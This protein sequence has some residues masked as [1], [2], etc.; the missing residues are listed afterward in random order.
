MSDQI[1]EIEDEESAITEITIA[2][3]GRI[4]VFGLS[5]PVI[6]ILDRLHPN[7]SRLKQLVHR[8]CHLE[9]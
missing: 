2:P 8:V 7:D 4:F 1:E 5:R 9:R 3:D 6:D